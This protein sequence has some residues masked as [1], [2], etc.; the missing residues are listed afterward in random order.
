LASNNSN[1]I[2]QS[3]NAVIDYTTIS[4]IIDTLNKQQKAISDLQ[5]ATM[6]ESLTV[7]SV[8]GNTVSNQGVQKVAG[9]RV[10]ITQNPIV[11]KYSFSQPPSSVVGVVFSATKTQTGYVYLS[12]APTATSATFNYVGKPLS[13]KQTGLFL[14]WMAVGIQ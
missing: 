10:A 1:Q 8:T 13:A 11:V 12:K 2:I 6:H 5:L 9:D 4:V 7:D 3:D 14:Y